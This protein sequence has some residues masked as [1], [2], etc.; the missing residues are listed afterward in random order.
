VGLR[1]IMLDLREEFAAQAGFSVEKSRA[2]W[3]EIKKA[4][5]LAGPSL[6]KGG[7]ILRVGSACPER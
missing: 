7:E 1:R 6:T 3:P 5:I 2:Y 4:G